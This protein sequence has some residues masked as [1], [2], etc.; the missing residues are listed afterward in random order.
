MNWRRD[1]EHFILQ[2]EVLQFS[3]LSILLGS[4]LLVKT[5]DIE[6]LD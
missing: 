2:P 5:T 4:I 3:E 1:Y 6:P